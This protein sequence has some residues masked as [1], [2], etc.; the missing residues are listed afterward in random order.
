VE[1]RSRRHHLLCKVF[2]QSSIP[3][4]H[5]ITPFVKVTLLSTLIRWYMIQCIGFYLVVLAV[6]NVSGCAA[7]NRFA[8][9]GLPDHLGRMH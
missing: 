6:C 4:L 1:S 3:L 9:A 2:C 5:V 8:C 7:F